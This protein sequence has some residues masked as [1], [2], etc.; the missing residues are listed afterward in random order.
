MILVVVEIIDII[1]N[2]G[3]IYAW[4]RIENDQLLTVAPDPAQTI[5]VKGEKVKMRAVVLI[6]ANVINIMGV[7]INVHNSI[8]A[9]L[10]KVAAI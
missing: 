4:I 1:A 7:C 3:S 8:L 2:K 5:V 6:I 10:G 9:Q